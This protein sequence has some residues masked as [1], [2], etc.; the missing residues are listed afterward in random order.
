L[1]LTVEQRFDAAFPPSFIVLIRHVMLACIPC[2]ATEVVPHAPFFSGVRSD[3]VGFIHIGSRYSFR[4][5]SRRS[6]RSAAPP[7][8]VGSDHLARR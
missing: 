2:A 8:P 6:A 3:F 7:H 4:D 1:F 5:H